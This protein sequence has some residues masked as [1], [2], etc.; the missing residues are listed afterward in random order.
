MGY[1]IGIHYPAGEKFCYTFQKVK[2][3]NTNLTLSN[4]G[5]LYQSNEN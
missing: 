2:F 4:C 1:E 5:K 3:A